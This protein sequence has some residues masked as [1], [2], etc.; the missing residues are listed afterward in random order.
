MK[1]K[2]PPIPALK[3][4]SFLIDSHCHL[5]MESYSDDLKETL[6]RAKR[7]GLQSII[8]IGIDEKSSFNAVKISQ[9]YS[10]VKATVGIH[11]HD[12]EK[13]DNATYDRLIELASN[14][15]TNVVGYGEIGL[16]YA[17]QY[18]EPV[19]Q[20]KAFREQLEIAKSLK[21]PVIIHDRNAH[22]DSLE[23]LR[24]AGPFPNGG[25]MHCFSGDLHFAQQIIDI[26]FLI[27]IPGIVTFKNGAEL[28]TVARKIPLQSLILETDGPFLAP[29]PWR[30]KRNEPSYLL[31]TAQKVAELRRLPIEEIANQTSNNV[32][33]LFKYKVEKR[34]S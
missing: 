1:K 29:E 5:D 9:T 11:P 15:R 26:G 33:N 7:H 12:V 18:A 28:Q 23:I 25:V 24:E 4:D 10:M 6:A 34:L 3:L 8:S 32:Q 16:D 21:L 17:K 27:S 2:R 20:K 30:G 13:T 19:I 22:D 14:N 31:Y